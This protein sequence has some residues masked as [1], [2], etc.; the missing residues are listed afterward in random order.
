MIVPISIVSTDGFLPLR[1]LMNHSELELW[2]S[3]YSMRPGKLFEGVEKHLSIFI[4][5]S[6]ESI[7]HSTRYHRWYTEERKNLFT[8]KP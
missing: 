7:I 5:V 2:Y 8:V 4:G 1:N 3:N 6:N